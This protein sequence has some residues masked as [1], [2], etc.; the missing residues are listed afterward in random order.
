MLDVLHPAWLE[1][2][3]AAMDLA[4]RN[5]TGKIGDSLP[6]NMSG[7]AVDLINDDPEAFELRVRQ[8]AYALSM[9]EA[10]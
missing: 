1:Y 3:R 10:G 4:R 9:G 5:L 7:E 2:D 8:C 6:L